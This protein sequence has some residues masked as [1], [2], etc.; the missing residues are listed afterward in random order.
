MVQFYYDFFGNS[1]IFEICYNVKG[2]FG[3]KSLSDFLFFI[4]VINDTSEFIFSFNNLIFSNFK[5]FV[6]N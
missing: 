6:I 3:I 4:A 2:L 1:G 5:C